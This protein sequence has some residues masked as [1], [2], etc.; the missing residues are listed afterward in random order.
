MKLGNFHLGVG[1]CYEC[2][3]YA[4]SV[5]NDAISYIR[6]GGDGPLTLEL[7]AQFIMAFSF[8]AKVSDFPVSV[9]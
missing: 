5:G 6:I 4:T 1:Y 7:K 9:A 8:L 3:T 2:A